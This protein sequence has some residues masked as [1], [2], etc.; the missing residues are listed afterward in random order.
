MR[1][2]CGLKAAS[3]QRP[4]AIFLERLHA[5]DA[6]VDSVMLIGHNPAIPELALS[7]AG[8]G[9]RLEGLRAKFPT[10]AL[11]TLEFHGSRVE[12]APGS[13]VLVFFVGPRELEASQS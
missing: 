9:A 6:E 7:L 5:V 11:A 4:P 3:T 8:S 12:L 1:S 10:A 13:A 2:T